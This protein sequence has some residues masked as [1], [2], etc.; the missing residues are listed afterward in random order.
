M[1][2]ICTVIVAN[3]NK[4]GVTNL[5]TVTVGGGAN[6]MVGLFSANPHKTG[7]IPA[8]GVWMMDG[9]RHANGL[10]VVTAGTGDTLTLTAGVGATMTVQVLVLGRT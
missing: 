5:N 3:K 4:A 10:G 8:G 1:G 2:S 6:E 7:P 9:S